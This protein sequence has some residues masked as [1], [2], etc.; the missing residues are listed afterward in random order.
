MD[1]YL[2]GSCIST[3]PLS[4]GKHRVSDSTVLGNRPD[5]VL[6]DKKEETYSLIDMVYQKIQTLTE[7]KLEKLAIKIGGQ[8]DEESEEKIVPI[9][10][11][12]LRKIRKRLD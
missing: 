1:I 9:L 6:H 3:V 12:A 2:K 8:Q 4:C 10:T 11:G 7:K 5:R